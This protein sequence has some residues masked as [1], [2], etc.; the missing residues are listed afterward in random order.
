M[1]LTHDK[2]SV[3]SCEMSEVGGGIS[4][5]GSAQLQGVEMQYDSL[6]SQPRMIKNKICKRTELLS[7]WVKTVGNR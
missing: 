1:E 7:K 2:H 3:V 5:N 6:S 4:R